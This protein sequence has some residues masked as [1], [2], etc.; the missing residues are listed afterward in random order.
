MLRRD[1]RILR[2][3]LALI[4]SIPLHALRTHDARRALSELAASRSSA[5][6]AIHSLLRLARVNAAQSEAAACQSRTASGCTPV[7]SK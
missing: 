3:A 2:P 5:S 1:E 4:G 6:A 7:L